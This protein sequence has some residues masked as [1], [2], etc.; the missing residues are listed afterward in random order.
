M[1]RITCISKY[2]IFL[3]DI[4]FQT[5]YIH[6]NWL[7]VVSIHFVKDLLW[8]YQIFLRTSFASA[9]TGTTT[10]V[11]KLNKN[12]YRKL[13]KKSSLIFYGLA[14]ARWWWALRTTA[15]HQRANARLSVLIWHSRVDGEH[16]GFFLKNPK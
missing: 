9:S 6:M 10:G 14:F 5:I 15:H 2:C 7:L 11:S 3:I 8:N 16:L 1:I 4:M 12:E 13:V